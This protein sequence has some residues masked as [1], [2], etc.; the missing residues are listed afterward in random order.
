MGTK[1]KIIEAAIDEFATHGYKASTIR[2]ICSRAGVNV[3]AINYHFSGKAEL[4]WKSFEHVFK[5]MS[6]HEFN[7]E[8]VLAEVKDTESLK[9]AVRAWVSF[10]M[11]QKL[12]ENSGKLRNLRQRLC[13][14]EMLDPSGVYDDLFKMFL[15]P[16]LDFLG[17]CFRLGCP[18]GITDDEINIRSFAIFGNCVFYFVHDRLVGYVYP[19]E[20]FVVNK[21]EKIV[22]C[23]V[24]LN[25]SDFEYQANKQA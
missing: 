25:C 16:D 1:S 7:A 9:S 3:A 21:F 17:K 15:K 4:Y 22:D 19:D 5:K 11:K 8:Q 12:F 23:I 6:P 2:R 14:Q 13:F 18:K 24:E 20:D 10:V